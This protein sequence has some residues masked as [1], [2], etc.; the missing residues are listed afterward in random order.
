MVLQPQ[1][2]GSEIKQYKQHRAGCVYIFN[3]LYV[4]ISNKEIEVM[5]L[6][7]TEYR[8]MEMARG[9]KCKGG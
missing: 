2:I 1:V 5:N 4:A 3:Y 8:N 6:R 7:G 9:K